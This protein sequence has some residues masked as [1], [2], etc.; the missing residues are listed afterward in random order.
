MSALAIALALGAA[1]ILTLTWG[2]WERAQAQTPDGARR[3]SR[4]WTGR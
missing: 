2:D 4:I 1:L 3:C